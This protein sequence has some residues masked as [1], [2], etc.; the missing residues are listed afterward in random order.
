[1]PLTGFSVYKGGFQRKV[2]STETLPGLFPCVSEQFSFHCCCA[3]FQICLVPN[4]I[5][6][7]KYA[8]NSLQSWT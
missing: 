7:N 3:K 2:N 8:E 1:M 5:C 4:F 6:R